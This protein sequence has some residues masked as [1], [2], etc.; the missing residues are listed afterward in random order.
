MYVGDSAGFKTFKNAL[1]TISDLHFGL[2]SDIYFGHR[3]F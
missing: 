3:I 1:L 2:F